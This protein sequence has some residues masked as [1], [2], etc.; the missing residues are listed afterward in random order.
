MTVSLLATWQEICHSPDD[1]QPN[2]LLVSTLSNTNQWALKSKLSEA[3]RMGGIEIPK[4]SKLRDRIQLAQDACSALLKMHSAGYLH[5]NLSSNVFGIICSDYAVMVE[6][7]DA[8]EEKAAA[9][10]LPKVTPSHALSWQAP[11]LMSSPDA[12]HTRETDV[13]AF[14][15]LLFD[16]VLGAPVSNLLGSSDDPKTI[17][18]SNSNPN[19]S[20]QIATSTPS[21][22]ADFFAIFDTWCATVFGGPL[23]DVGL[24]HVVFRDSDTKA[25][26]LIP[27]GPIQ[28]LGAL[29]ALCCHHSPSKRPSPSLILASLETVLLETP[30]F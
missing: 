12:P 4:L 17:A 8:I 18:G 2:L 23:L 28:R 24:T 21:G 27:N 22:T 14:G 5:R 20:S 10:P 29:I 15:V 16:L 11:E 30:A 19:T 9:F 1:S 3:A 25:T 7:L 13:F 26:E 6:F